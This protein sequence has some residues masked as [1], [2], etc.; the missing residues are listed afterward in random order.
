MRTHRDS[1][2][3]PYRWTI[4]SLAFKNEHDPAGAKA[5]WVIGAPAARAVQVLETLQPPDVTALFRSTLWIRRQGAL[6]IARTNQ[7][8]NDFITWINAYCADHDRTDSIAQIEGAA[9]TLST[10]QFRRTLAWHI[11]RRPG[12]AIAGAIQF[13]HLSIQMFE[14]YAGTSDSGFRAE[15][16]AE[17]A[18]A[19]GEH[20]LALISE[21]EHPALTGPAAPEATRRLEEFAEQ[22]RFQGHVVTDPR[23]VIRLMQRHDP[24]IY[25]GTYI[26]CMFDPAKA[27]C[28]QRR[29]STGTPRPSPSTCQPLDCRNTTLTRQNVQTLHEETRRI[30]TELARIPALPPLLAA[31]LSERRTKITTFLARHDRQEQP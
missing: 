6:N 12:G 23:R 30:D 19:R 18:L 13:R 7:L 9:W 31:R 16:E 24:A 15:V 1:T 10:R 22:A 26:T 3:T 20:L 28:Q 17:Q 14:G 8:L 27:L 2:G 4:T 11:A 29:D 21:H 25:P 5:T